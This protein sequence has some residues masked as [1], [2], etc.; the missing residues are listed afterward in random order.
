MIAEAAYEQGVMKKAVLIFLVLFLSAGA[1]AQK[2]LPGKQRGTASTAAVK[3]TP[4]ILTEKEQFEAASA[5]EL[6]PERIS[7]LQKFL[8]DFPESGNRIPAQELIES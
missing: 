8:T 4:K 5:L 1:I 7:A 2:P 6:A 3:P